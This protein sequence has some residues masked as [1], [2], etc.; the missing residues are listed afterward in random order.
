MTAKSVL[1]RPQ[2]GAAP[3]GDSENSPPTP[4]KGHICKSSETDEK[5]LGVWRGSDVTNHTWIL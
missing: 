4:L 1:M 5:I 2:Q 3:R